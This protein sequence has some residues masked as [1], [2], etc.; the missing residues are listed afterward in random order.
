MGN[1]YFHTCENRLLHCVLDGGIDL[2]RDRQFFDFVLQF[3]KLSALKGL[4]AHKDIATYFH[5]ELVIK[6]EDSN[7]F[8]K[9][10]R[11]IVT[12]S[13]L[14]IQRCEDRFDVDL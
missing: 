5:E 13:N 14:W 4:N 7:I 6:E 3:F 11:G 12:P 2:I 1:K 9:Y 8:K 10:K